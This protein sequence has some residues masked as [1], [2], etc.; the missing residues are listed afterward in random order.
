MTKAGRPNEIALDATSLN[1]FL[2]QT[3]VIAGKAIGGQLD[4][5]GG[6]IQITALFVRM[7]REREFQIIPI[8]RYSLCH[9]ITVSFSFGSGGSTP[10]IPS[11]SHKPN[12]KPVSTFDRRSAI[13]TEN[14]PYSR[15]NP[16][17]SHI[18]LKS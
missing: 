7:H 18:Q 8:D 16:N 15:F 3:D 12:L 11:M 9:T 2:G 1:L 4:L 13:A 5:A 6:Q 10:W 14:R 17:S